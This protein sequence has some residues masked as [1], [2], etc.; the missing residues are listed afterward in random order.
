M[1]LSQEEVLHL[2]NLARLH[3]RRSEI[4][5]YQ[6][7][8]GLVLSYVRQLEAVDTSMVKVGLDSG[9]LANV[10]REDQALPFDGEGID[11]ALNQAGAKKGQAIKVRRILA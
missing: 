2:A 7:Q 5:K 4:K 9:A 11:L 1:I 3:L 6:R 10:W 8:L